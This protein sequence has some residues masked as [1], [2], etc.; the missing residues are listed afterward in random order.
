MG[1]FGRIIALLALALLGLTW[2][3]Q[4]GQAAG[5]ADHDGL[6]DG[7][8]AA[9]AAAFFPT[10]VWF[11]PD[12][13]C[14][15]PATPT[16]PGMAA[17]HAQIDPRNPALI[18]ITYTLH[19]RQDCG[20]PFHGIDSHI[21]DVETFSVTLAPDANC[22]LGWQLY[23]LRAVAHGGGPANIEE[24]VYQ[25]C[26]PA[27]ELFVSLSKH[28][29]YLSIAKCEAYADPFQVCGR[30]FSAPFELVQ[31]GEDAYRLADD[32]SAYFPPE[33]GAP[34][35]YLWLNPGDGLFCGGVLVSDRSE[36]VGAAYAKFRDPEKLAPTADFDT[37]FSSGETWRT[38]AYPTSLA[39]GDVDGDGRAEV[40]VARYD[41]AGARAALYDDAVAGYAL[42][43]AYGGDWNASSY[44][45][46]VALGDVDGDGLA[47]IALGR[48]AE[49]G[50]RFFVFDDAQ[51]AFAP[52]LSL[53]RDWQRGSYP[54]AL[55]LGDVDGD[56]RAELGVALHANRGDRLLVLDDALN[57]F[58]NLLAYGADW[59]FGRYP[60]AL[61]LG[62][63]DGD[64]ALEVAVA[65][66]AR[67]G[68]RLLVLDDYSADFALLFDAGSDWDANQSATTLA[69]GDIDGD[70]RVE[71]M[72]GRRT[73]VGER[74]FFYD[75][76]LDAFA[77][78]HTAGSDW[79]LGVYPTSLAAGDLDGDS[80]AELLVG[81]S[82]RLNGRILLIDDALA[83]RPFDLAVIGGVDWAR[84][85]S[86]T[87]VGLG[88]APDDGRRQVLIGRAAGSG[89]RWQVWT[90]TQP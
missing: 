59:G 90:L 27:P 16:T 38:A 67:D 56:G 11:H 58:A 40:V 10:T 73:L 44:A 28:A 29:T 82:A 87:T 60:T 26:T 64:A 54:I 57:N 80:R 31:A 3:A 22:A 25:S 45:T 75:D 63:L 17:Y 32:L 41:T 2:L 72:L 61:A 1:R 69:L 89:P 47:E 14:A 79:E 6:D 24:V 48:A 34:V 9:L 49:S 86:A 33:A 51:H 70:S 68:A 65:R 62:N 53:G 20:S 66:T 52:L 43:A 21:G 46:A 50:D 83:W 42:L 77:L 8:E 39:A 74:L 36:C 76:A 78:L 12:E 30:G 88:D 55:S 84:G 5:D 37:L 35:D 71:V 19:Y 18:S 85:Q 23:A 7:L 15:W 13:T 4:P 81:R